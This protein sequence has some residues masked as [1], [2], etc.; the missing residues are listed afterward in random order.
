MARRGRRTGNHLAL[1]HRLTA[2]IAMADKDLEDARTQM[3]RAVSTLANAERST[4]ARR[5]DRTADAFHDSVGDAKI[6]AGYRD[7][8]GTI[9]QTLAATLDPADSLRS[10]LLTS[11]SA[12]DRTER[13]PETVMT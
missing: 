11:T 7:R 10:S 8:H 4:K 3:D 13:S 1:A 9:V 12:G 5:I 6:A 2:R